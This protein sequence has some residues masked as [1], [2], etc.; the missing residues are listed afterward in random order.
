[1]TTSA[2]QKLTQFLPAQN[3]VMSQGSSP[4]TGLPNHKNPTLP[5]RFESSVPSTYPVHELSIAQV[6][7][8]I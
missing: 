6:S 4:V 3:R 5:T 2:Q 8:V 1:M 7:E